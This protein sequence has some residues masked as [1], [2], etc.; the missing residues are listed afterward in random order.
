MGREDREDSC[1]PIILLLLFL[2]LVF[3]IIAWDWW[4]HGPSSQLDVMI[5]RHTGR[6]V[7]GRPWIS[8]AISLGGIL[9]QSFFLGTLVVCGGI[10]LARKKDWPG[11]S[12]L[13]IVVILGHLLVEPLQSWFHRPRPLPDLAGAQGFSFPS[14]S[15]YLAAVVY[16]ALAFL[17]ATHTSKWWVKG[18]LWL[19]ALTATLLAGMSRL[20]LCLYWF[21]DILGAYA[22]ACSWLLLNFLVYRKMR[23]KLRP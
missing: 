21:T 11:L 6:L 7:A 2:L 19:G 16:G 17:A 13:L 10:F 23:P 12:L 15:A 22:L 8:G 9:G 14:G 1:T 3:E 20:G 5:L 4:R 18:A